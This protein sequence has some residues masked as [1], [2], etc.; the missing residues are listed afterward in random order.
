MFRL[1][2]AQGAY[3]SAFT[4]G[5]VGIVYSCYNLINVCCAHPHLSFGL[6]GYP[7]GQTRDRVDIFIHSIELNPFLP[8]GPTL[9][10]SA[11]SYPRILRNDYGS[12]RPGACFTGI[13]ARLCHR[14]LNLSIFPRFRAVSSQNKGVVPCIQ[15]SWVILHS[16]CRRTAGAFLG[17]DPSPGNDC[18]RNPTF[19]PSLP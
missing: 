12:L 3:Y 13:M 16:V 10:G 4:V 19:R 17:P 1:T 6:T 2:L 18:C 11:A 9:I 5:C 8:H 15:A 7:P 14:L